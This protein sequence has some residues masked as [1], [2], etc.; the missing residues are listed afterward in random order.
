[1]TDKERQSVELLGRVRSRLQRGPY[2]HL[3]I[4]ADE[5]V[6]GFLVCLEELEKMRAS[7]SK[8]QSDG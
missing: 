3:S 4:K 5:I 7:E 2:A 1:M 6:I 8:E